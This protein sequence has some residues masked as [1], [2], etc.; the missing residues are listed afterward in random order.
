M[1]PWPLGS[2]L[3]DSRRMVANWLV[4]LSASVPGSAVARA[5]IMSIGCGL[6]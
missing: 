5:D 6:K 2:M 3:K 4:R 1:R